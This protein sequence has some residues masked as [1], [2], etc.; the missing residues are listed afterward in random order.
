MRPV[1]IAMPKGRL[2]APLVELFSRAGLFDLGPE[3]DLERRLTVKT[4]DGRWELLLVKPADVPIYVEYG[5]ADLG[6][7]GKDVLL[8]ARRELCE[9]Y[10]L[11]V[12]RCRLIMAVPEDSP[13]RKATD[14]IPGSRV[15]TKFPR[16]AQEYFSS[17]G[18]QVDIVKLNGSIE[19]A[20]KAGLAS[21]IVD[22][23][24]TGRTL[25]QNQLRIVEEIMSVS[26][27]LICNR[28][29]YK[30]RYPL[31]QELVRGLQAVE[32]SKR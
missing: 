5:A 14:L 29:S 26:A 3:V 1:T 13:I 18:I 4:A 10:D 16:L 30:V 22:I 9:L 2:F 24:E 11:G 28:I 21:A 12:G 25:A 23:T 20:P 8:E 27:R 6:V 32:V 19:L 15:A 31:I 17:H 7:A